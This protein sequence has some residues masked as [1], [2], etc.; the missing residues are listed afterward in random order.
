MVLHFLVKKLSGEPKTACVAV[1]IDQWAYWLDSVHQRIQAADSADKRRTLM[2][3]FN[4]RFPSEAV[5]VP[6][7]SSDCKFFMLPE[8]CI[9]LGQ[10]FLKGEKKKLS[11][12][13]KCF[14][15]A[16]ERGDRTGVAAMA[17]CY[18]Y[19]SSKNEATREN[20]KAARRYL[21][22]A[23]LQTSTKL[24]GKWRDWKVIGRPC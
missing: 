5:M 4:K 2:D 21:K 22:K 17:A 6:S 20:K 11:P 9:Q 15:Q 7:F 3:E 16:M 19:V 10:A 13:L 1:L 14:E 18:C 12:A 23:K 24:D 8:Y